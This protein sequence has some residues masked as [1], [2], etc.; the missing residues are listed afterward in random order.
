MFLSSADFS[1]FLPILFVLAANCE[2]AQNAN[3]AMARDLS[4]HW[5]LP[6]LNPNCRCALALE[7]FSFSLSFWLSICAAVKVTE[8]SRDVT[9]KWR[10]TN[11]A[12]EKRF[13]HRAKKEFCTF[14][15]N[16]RV[17]RLWQARSYSPKHGHQ[18]NT[19]NIGR[20]DA[21]DKWMLEVQI[22]AIGSR[23]NVHPFWGFLVPLSKRKIRRHELS[24]CALTPMRILT[25][26]RNDKKV[27]FWFVHRAQQSHPR[28]AN[29]HEMVA[30]W[31]FPSRVAW[32]MSKSINHRLSTR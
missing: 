8:F 23:E 12:Q 3:A 32:K 9:P 24:M 29:E 15:S 25:S 11:E 7:L 28:H 5:S 1:W 17:Y 6:D 27:Y 4:N 10:K 16:S 13:Q 26:V 30:E 2:D 14:S 19:I 20:W 22:Y 21:L 31:W 18:I